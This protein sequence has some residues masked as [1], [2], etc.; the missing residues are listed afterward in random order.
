MQGLQ[1][2]KGEMDTGGMIQ[3]RSPQALEVGR[4]LKEGEELPKQNR[5]ELAQ[6]KR[7]RGPGGSFWMAQ[8]RSVNLATGKSW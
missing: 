3:G 4:G 7:K 1:E 8:E 6:T 2:G 5:K